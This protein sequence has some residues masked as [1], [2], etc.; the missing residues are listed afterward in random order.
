METLSTFISITDIS[1]AHDVMPNT[2]EDVLNFNFANHYQ[3]STASK[4]STKQTGLTTMTVGFSDFG[5]DADCGGKRL[6][7]YYR[8]PELAEHLLDRLDRQPGLTQ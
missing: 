2:E 8:K 1:R 6:P 7:I 5:N 4:G 3:Q